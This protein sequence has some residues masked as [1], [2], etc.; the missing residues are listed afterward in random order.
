MMWNQFL[1]E[2]T[3]NLKTEVDIIDLKKEKSNSFDEEDDDS[4]IENNEEDT[5]ENIELEARFTANKIK[6]LME[7]NYQIYDRKKESFRNITYKDIV[8]LLRST[9]DKANVFERELTNLN[10]PVFSDTS[11]EYLNS[12]EI[13][14]IMSLLKIID[15]PVQD[16]PLVTVLR[17]SIF[18]FTDNELIRN[19]VMW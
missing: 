14:T 12:I 13:E 11:Q 3:Q 6:D 9:K 18:G 2:I 15:N 19:K 7:N 10:I 5:L 16:I 17:S 1:K 8:I 4:N